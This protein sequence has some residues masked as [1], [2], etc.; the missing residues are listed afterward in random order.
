MVFIFLGLSNN[1]ICYCLKQEKDQVHLSF[2]QI[3][4][5]F[6]FWI[7]SFLGSPIPIILQLSWGIFLC[8]LIEHTICWVLIECRTYLT[9]CSLTNMLLTVERRRYSVI[10]FNLLFFPMFYYSLKIS[11]LVCIMMDLLKGRLP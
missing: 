7:L 3:I 8:T 11:L 9:P 1:N 4:S 2:T 5:I 10:H 6:P